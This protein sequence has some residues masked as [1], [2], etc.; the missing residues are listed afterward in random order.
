[1]GDGNQDLCFSYDFSYLPHVS[2]CMEAYFREI[3]FQELFIFFGIAIDYK[4]IFHFQISL[5]Y[6]ASD[7]AHSLSLFFRWSR[8]S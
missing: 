7:L 5:P 4:Y 3:R 8:E 6:P 1:M 2:C